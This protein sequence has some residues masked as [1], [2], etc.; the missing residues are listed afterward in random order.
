MPDGSCGR[1]LRARPDYSLPHDPPSCAPLFVCVCVCVQDVR[2][3]ITEA[4]AEIAAREATQVELLD[5]S[6]DLARQ[7]TV[8]KSS[9]IFVHADAFTG[10]G[11][12]THQMETLKAKLSALEVLALSRR[13]ICRWVDRH[14]FSVS[15]SI[16][17]VTRRTLIPQ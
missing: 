17:G 14:N 3:K 15:V 12:H 2:R 16:F 5:K 6:Q 7:L 9:P 1:T 13:W 11:V 10:K 4:K 8:N